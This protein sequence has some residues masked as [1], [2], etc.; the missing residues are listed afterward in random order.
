MLAVAL[1][2]CRRQKNMICRPMQFMLASAFGAI[3]FYE[4]ALLAAAEVA[5]NLFYALYL[6]CFTWTCAALLRFVLAYTRRPRLPAPIY[7]LLLIDSVSSLLNPIFGHAYRLYPFYLGDMRCWTFQTQIGLLG[8]MLLCYGLTAVIFVYLIRQLIRAPRLYQLQYIMLCLVVAGV[9]AVNAVFLLTRFP[10]DYSVLSFGPAAVLLCYFTFRFLPQKMIDGMRR[11]VWNNSKSAVLLFNCYGECI[12]TNSYAE[13]WFSLQK[14]PTLEAW[15]TTLQ[16]E[17]S[18]FL[19]D[20]RRQLKLGEGI[21]EK[22]YQT[23]FVRL[24]DEKN[25]AMGCFFVMEDVT[26]GVEA[27]LKEQYRVTHDEMTGIYNKQAFM[28]ETKKLLAK[29]PNR[30]FYIIVTNIQQFKLINDM[31]GKAAADELLMTIGQHLQAIRETDVVAGRLESDHFA[32]CT[33]KEYCLEKDFYIKSAATHRQV[34]FPIA[35]VNH[36]GIYEVTDRTVPVE[37][38]CD[39]AL[40]AC[41]SLRGNVQWQIAYY[42]NQLRSDL[43]REN[44]MVSQFPLALAQKQFV[45]YFQP[46]YDYHTGAVV[47]AEALVRWQHPQFGLLAPGAF[48]P[49][50]ER[51]GLIPQMDFYCWDLACQIIQKLR[52]HMPCVP[53]SISVNVST[54]DFYAQDLYAIFTGLVVKY[55]IPARSLK[56]EITESV[57]M[58]D[59][60]KQRALLQRL[61]ASGFL[62]EMD[63]FGSGY[64][65]LNTLKDIPVDVLKMDLR[66]LEDSPNDAV[67]QKILRAIIGLSQSMQIPVIAEGVETQAQADRLG[68][69]G[70]RFM[71]G[72]YYAKPMP[73]KD[74]VELLRTAQIDDLNRIYREEQNAWAG[75]FYRELLE[76]QCRQYDIGK[77]K[78]P[79]KEKAPDSE[80]SPTQKQN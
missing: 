8:H 28:Q 65:S 10:L 17:K 36:F 56:L 19:Q 2:F 62:I 46:Q 60:P 78:V 25:R 63:D 79:D 53:L 24:K 61:Q 51:N 14:K 30:A 76:K 58:L 70:C 26:E 33:P 73:L 15:K 7:V 5:A 12:Y 67:S 9:A 66:F 71:Q 80:E 57:A 35:I 41:G 77:E 49:L 21:A 31:M 18:C 13:E 3:L 27:Y 22:Y 34:N 39:R 4:I 40:L 68:A 55:G 16:L 52:G 43:L 69:M 50:F 23:Q 72:Y 29:Y 74:F 42:D 75:G 20:F 32:V 37:V 38:M 59:V 64:S 11:L 54:R 45:L 48:V 44:E 6:V 47:G 1:L